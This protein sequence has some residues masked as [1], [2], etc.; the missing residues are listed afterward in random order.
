LNQVRGEYQMIDDEQ[1]VIETYL[2]QYEDLDTRGII[3]EEERL[4][5]IE[6]LRDAALAIKLPS[7]QYE[8]YPQEEY[9]R[10]IPLPQGAFKVWSST[11]RLDVGLLHEDDLVSLLR[12]IN[13]GANG[14]FTVSSCSLRRELGEPKFEPRATNLTASCELEWLTIRQPVGEGDSA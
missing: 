9:E 3:G 1:R 7:L 4:N 8:L 5:W 11:M 14:L 12:R 10:D 13:R 6:T 2:P